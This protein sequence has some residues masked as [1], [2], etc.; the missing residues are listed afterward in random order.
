ME[1]NKALCT[2]DL[3]DDK[4]LLNFKEG[5]SYDIVDDFIGGYGRVVFLRDEQGFSHGIT[6]KWLQCFKFKAEE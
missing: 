1:N 3:Y 6:D 2:K 4:G 5:E